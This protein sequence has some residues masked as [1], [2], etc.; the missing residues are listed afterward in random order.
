MYICVLMN[1]AYIYHALT[2]INIDSCIYILYTH[3]AGTRYHTALQPYTLNRLD[4][5]RSRTALNLESPV[6][7]CFRQGFSNQGSK[8]GAFMIMRVVQWFRA[9]FLSRSTLSP[10]PLNPIS[11]GL[12]ALFIICLISTPEHTI[13]SR[14]HLWF[15]KPTVVRAVPHML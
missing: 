10:K 5:G 4:T 9:C 8:F 12:I 6:C 13:T 11:W 3:I 1:F 14:T 7:F 2:Y 15:L